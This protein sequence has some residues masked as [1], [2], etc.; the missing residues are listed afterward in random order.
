MTNIVFDASQ[1]LIVAIVAFFIGRYLTEKIAFLDRFRIPE[2]VTGGL[3]VSV[4]VSL[5]KW[6]GGFT[7]SFTSGDMAMLAFFTT[8]GLNARLTQLFNTLFHI[9]KKIRI[10]T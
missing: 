8:I 1:T 4:C 3:L 9:M 2:A 7:I 6:W 5:L 10:K